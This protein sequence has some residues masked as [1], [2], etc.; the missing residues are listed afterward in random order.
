MIHDYHVNAYGLQKETLFRRKRIVISC[1][2]VV[3]LLAIFV[4]FFR[5]EE[6]RVGKECM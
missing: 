5:S 1:I 4:L 2:A 6:R 3:L